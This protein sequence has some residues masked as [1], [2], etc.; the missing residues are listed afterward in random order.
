MQLLDAMNTMQAVDLWI[1]TCFREKAVRILAEA[2]IPVHV[3]GQD[4]E[5]VCWKQPKN[6][7]I[8]GK[9][10][11]SAQCVQFM[12]QAK[13]ALNTMPWFKDGAH[14]RI[15]TAMLQGAVS[16]TDDSK[17]LRENFQ[18]WDTLV[19]YDLHTLEQLPELVCSLLRD[20]ERMYAISRRAKETA[21]QSHTWKQRAQVLRKWMDL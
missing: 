18:D 2:G 8:S 7:T 3:V 1:R 21:E 19:Y 11:D 20:P 13:I 6:L 17:Y 4:W 9:A 15:F 14:D 12:S 10:L 16:L 5:Q